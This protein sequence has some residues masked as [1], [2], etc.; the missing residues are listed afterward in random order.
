MDLVRIEHEL[1]KRLAFPYRWGRRQSNNFDQATQFIYQTYSFEFLLREIERRFG[2]LDTYE[3]YQDYAL[4]RWFNFWSAQ[5][6]EQIFCSLSGV[7]PAHNPRNRLVDFSFEGISF[8]HKTTIFPKSFPQNLASAQDNPRE[9]I[10]WLY[11]NQSQEK[12]MH[13]KNRLFIVLHANDGE[14]WKLK[15]DIGWLQT[16]IEQYVGAFSLTQ[17][18]TFHFAHDSPTLSDVIWALR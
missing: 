6:V 18:H 4:N 11:D 12:R 13:L 7:K 1:Q 9:L 2:H 3:S 5:A 8:D 10:Q 14:H 16:I 17:L 15:A